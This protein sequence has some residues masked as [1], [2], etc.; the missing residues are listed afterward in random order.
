MRDD[1]VVPGT[2]PSLSKA[3]HERLV[4]LARR[5]LVGWEADAEDVVHLTYV[6]WASLSGST[7]DVAR[8]EQVVKSAADSWRRSD[9]RRI[10]REAKYEGRRA[11][12]HDPEADYTEIDLSLMVREL[13]L[14]AI[15][16]GVSISET[17]LKILRHLLDGESMTQIAAAMNRSRYEIRQARGRWQH[18]WKMSLVGPFS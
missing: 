8:I 14:L 7:A 16:F 17:D 10:A 4:W 9:N 6:K 18:V 1:K 3:G 13:E 11:R 12:S 2:W 15:G 5:R